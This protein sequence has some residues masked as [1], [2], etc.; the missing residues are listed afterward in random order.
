LVSRHL[1]FPDIDGFWE[2]DDLNRTETKIRAMVPSFETKW[3]GQQLQLAT[4]LA[5]VLALQGQLPEAR[6]T[7]IACEKHLADLN[8]AEKVEAEIRLHLEQG[9]FDCLSNSPAKGIHSFKL[10]WISAEKAQQIVHLIDAAYMFSITLP[11]KSGREWL[12]RAMKLAQGTNDPR[13]NQWWPHLYIAEGWFYFDSHQFDKALLSFDQAAKAM[14][15]SKDASL[16]KN[17]AWCRGRTLRATG[18]INEALQ[19]Q[20]ATLKNLNAH[21]G[22]NGFIYLEMA[23]CYLALQNHEKA[24]A[25]FLS[26]HEYLHQYKW[27]AD[28]HADELERMK[29]LGKK[30]Y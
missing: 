19:I 7:L 9:R 5:R 20:E 29:K 25:A 3:T 28:N 8:E 2:N 12:E 24:Q 26:A 1:A 16:E 21:T 18:K 23:E 17:I 4:Q 30:S 13:A 22:N 27:Y 11:A 15:D 6:Q 10:A 14:G